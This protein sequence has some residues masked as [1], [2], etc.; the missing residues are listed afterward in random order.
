MKKPTP[1]P[2]PVPSPGKKTS[3]STNDKNIGKAL[4]VAKQGLAAVSSVAGIFTEQQRTHQ[5]V[6]KAH[7]NVRQAEEETSRRLIDARKRLA[8]LAA[9]DRKDERDHRH[10]MQ[11]LAN[12]RENDTARIRQQDRLLDHVLNQT[13]A[14]S[15]ALEQSVRALLTNPGGD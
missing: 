3:G 5:A 1:K 14:D 2:K 6:T 15:P 8:E 13:T 4:D 12:R 11:E 10:K 9:E 7:A